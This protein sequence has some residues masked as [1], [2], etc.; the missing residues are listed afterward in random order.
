MNDLPDKHTPD[1]KSKHVCPWQHVKTFDNFLRPFF[2]DPLKIFGPFVGPGMTVLDVGCG[3]GFATLSMAG[4]MGDDGLVIAADLQPQMLEMVEQRAEKAGLSKRIRTHQCLA[5][6]IG[7][8]DELDF[9]LA[10]W[11]AHEVPDAGA[12][13]EEI[14]GLLKPSG[15]LLIAEPKFHVTKKALE[16][17]LQAGRDVGFEVSEGPRITFSRSALLTKP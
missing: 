2:H 5:D 14:F 9:A 1:T 6:R 17:T 15:K 8:L 12:F 11:M 4:L 3:R 16:R 7:V 13:L 10:F